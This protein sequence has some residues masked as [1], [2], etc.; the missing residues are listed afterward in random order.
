[1]LADQPRQLD[2]MD[3]RD[4]ADIDLGITEGGSVAGDNHVAGYRNRHAAR[5]YRAID[6]GDGRLAHPVLD[7]VECE[8]EFLEKT[9]GFG[10]A[11]AS[12]E[13]EIEP[14]AEHLVG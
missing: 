5:P 12:D 4:Q 9:L 2:E 11:L 8:I 7:V 3:R 13:V 10:R 6:G 14:G 1:M